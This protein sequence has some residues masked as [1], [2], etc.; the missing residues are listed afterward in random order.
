MLRSG[1]PKKQL[2]GSSMLGT[3]AIEN[4]MPLGHAPNAIEL[5]DGRIFVTWFCASY[6][7]AQD[8]RLAG[9]LRSQDGIWSPTHTVVDR[10]ESQGEDW[11]PGTGVP[12]QGPEGE[13]RLYFSAFPVS[14]GFKLISNPCYV[15][16]VG[17]AGPGAYTRGET[18]CFQTPALTKDISTSRLFFTILRSDL[19]LGAP[20][21]FW[22][23]MGL[24]LMG[25]ALRLQSG[26]W[27]LPYH[28]WGRSDCPNHSRFFISD[29]NLENWE[30]RG[31]LF[32]EPGCVEPSVVQFP[33]GDIL[34]FMRRRGKD[35]HIWQAVSSDGCETL[36]GPFRT[37][38]RNPDAGVDIALSGL[39]GRLLVAYNDSYRQRVPLCVGVSS[40]RGRTWRVRDVESDAGNFAYPKILQSRDGIWHLFY[41]YDYRH[42][43]HAWFD[44][45]WLE[46]GR[47]V[48]G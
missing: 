28:T 25:A 8:E 36:A 43:Q 21:L 2:A 11:V 15:R 1:T 14:S 22:P 47:R 34:C 35:G 48:F 16:I 6:E 5:D 4:I 17:G 20:Q 13:I 30:T 29:E 7:G 37:N 18:I 19:A 38:L 44:E 41:S 23:D 10:F 31:D 27:L 26:R 32:A 39:S 9:A 3:E 46:G 24:L 40:D 33:S 42:I 45:G 12:L